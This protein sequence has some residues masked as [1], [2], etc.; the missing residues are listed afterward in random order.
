MRYRKI[1]Q[2]GL[3]VSELGFGGLPL[4]RST[5]NEVNDALALATELGINLIDTAPAYGD[6]EEKIG[7][8]LAQ[9]RD[10]WIISTKTRARE[11]SAVQVDLEQSLK[12]LR[13]DWLDI[14]LFHD[15]R[16]PEELAQIQGEVLNYLLKQ[17]AAG[18]IRALGVSC[19]YPTMVDQL[20]PLEWVDVVMVPYNPLEKDLF[21]GHISRLAEYGKGCLVMKPLCGGAIKN[22]PLALQFALQAQVSSVLVGMGSAAE[23]MANC[24]A[25]EGRTSSGPQGGAKDEEMKELTA[26]VLQLGQNFCRQCEYCLPCP[27]GVDIPDIFRLERY[28]TTYHSQDWASFQYRQLAVNAMSCQE[29]RRCVE[30]CPYNLNI[31]E[32]LALADRILRIG[33]GES[34]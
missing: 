10:S 11:L 34:T 31:P 16:W 26:E 2:P 25:I 6:G 3:T 28:A 21:G 13:T 22:I 29:C 14:Y 23:V 18:R 5:Q 17:K 32:K 9:R 19:H 33:G 27:V 1:D 7:N 20:I 30:R 4:L 15:L 8:G 24:Q 12:R